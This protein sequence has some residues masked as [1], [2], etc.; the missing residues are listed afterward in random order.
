[1]LS[2]IKIQS[3]PFQTKKFC[4]LYKKA[5]FTHSILPQKVVFLE[6][7]ATILS[8]IIGT[9]FTL[10]IPWLGLVLPPRRWTLPWVRT[11]PHDRCRQR[12]CRSSPRTWCFGSWKK[13][14]SIRTWKNCYQHFLLIPFTVSFLNNTPITKIKF[15]QNKLNSY[16]NHKKD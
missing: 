13:R 15:K 2:Q 7:D 1:M 3:S 8:G 14:Q 12:L 6:T 16:K 9:D 5:W 4:L 10:A 11:R